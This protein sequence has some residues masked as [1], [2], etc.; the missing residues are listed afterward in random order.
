MG[1]AVIAGGTPGQREFKG[2]DR[3]RAGGAF[4]IPDQHG[5]SVGA[6]SIFRYT[7]LN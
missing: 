1:R 4:Y 6:S 5:D 2:P 7:L 3:L